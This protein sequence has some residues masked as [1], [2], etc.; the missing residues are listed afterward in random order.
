MSDF[1]DSPL[2]IDPDGWAPKTLVDIPPEMVASI[3]MG[4]EDPDEI[5]ARHGFTGA[6][7]AKLKAWKPFNDTVAI[8]KVE[9]E[10]S[11]VTFRLKSAMKAD[12]LADQVFVKAMG[13]DV[14]LM[15]KLETL[16][17]LTKVGD[18]EPKTTGSLTGGEGF[19]ISINLGGVPGQPNSQ[20][21]TI[22]V[23]DVK[24]RPVPTDPAMQL[25][26]ELDPLVDPALL[27]EMA[28]NAAEE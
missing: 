22:V 18:L 27:A 17:F 15:Q 10:K 14:S 4:M 21:Q 26:L 6:R 19:S 28:A 9:F 25:P 16:K 20:P 13:V 8:Q 11:G 24:P 7:W 12:M 23:Q 5:A 1:D 3:A 2:E